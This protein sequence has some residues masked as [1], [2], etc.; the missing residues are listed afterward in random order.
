MRFS[1][2]RAVGFYLLGGSCLALAAWLSPASASS[3]DKVTSS[4]A[5][6]SY[7]VASPEEQASY[8]KAVSDAVASGIAPPTTIPSTSATDRAAAAEYQ[9]KLTD[10]VSVANKEA[11]AAIEAGKPLDRPTELVLPKTDRVNSA[12]PPLKS[13]RLAPGEPGTEADLRTGA[14][15]KFQSTSNYQSD[16]VTF[17]SVAGYAMDILMWIPSGDSQTDCNGT[18]SGC[19]WFNAAASWMNNG[20]GYL[21]VGPEHG[22]SFC[23]STGAAWKTNASGYNGGTHTPCNMGSTPDVPTDQWVLVR[24]W[25]IASQPGPLWT[26]TYGIF[27]GPPGNTPYAGSVTLNGTSLGNQPHYFQEVYE[28]NG[29]CATN[30][31][32]TAFQG[33][34]MWD[35]NGGTTYLNS[36]TRSFNAG[37]SNTDMPAYAG[38]YGFDWRNTARVSGGNGTSFNL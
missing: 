16:R 2:I 14:V 30:R 27:V 26:R 37:C 25:E 35:Y 28:T 8:D 19:F 5:Q 4:E 10:A 31:S 6:A 9:Q 11:L 24:A 17:G 15:P 22:V 38:A 34:T 23:G 18:A 12:A 7:D 13:I 36:G 29:P 32:W 33:I 3:S 20:N 1:S 21:H